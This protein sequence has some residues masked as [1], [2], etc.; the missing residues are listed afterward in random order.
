MKIYALR[1][2]L[3]NYFMLPF[4]APSD[5]DVLA[6]IAQQVNTQESMSAIAQAPHHFEIWKLGEVDDQ[7][8]ITPKKEL[9]ADANSLIRENIR[10]KPIERTNQMEHAA[11]G[12]E[13]PH[14]RPS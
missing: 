10:P 9:L 11:I 1:D 6:G 12:S 4:A 8:H 13:S 7:G 3:I 14:G 2:K 5:A